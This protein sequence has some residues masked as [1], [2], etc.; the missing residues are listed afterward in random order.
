MLQAV[1]AV[2]ALLTDRLLSAALFA[3]ISLVAIMFWRWAARAARRA[4]PGTRAAAVILFA[5]ATIDLVKWW[6]H[7]LGPQPVM[8][9]FTLE[10]L[11]GLGATV[12][13]FGKGSTAYFRRHR[14]SGRAARL[15]RAWR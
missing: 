4:E 9:V 1:A 10:W 5:W 15:K 3:G 7:S 2:I 8:I 12:L 11:A 6:R 13:L 14:A